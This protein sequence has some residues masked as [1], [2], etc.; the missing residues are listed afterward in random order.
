MLETGPHDSVHHS[1]NGEMA[2]YNAPNDMMLQMHHANAN[3]IWAQWQEAN[4]ARLSDYE[5]FR[6]QSRTQRASVDDELLVYG[7]C[8]RPPPVLRR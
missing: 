4:A 8:D 7:L 1:V 2:A 3:R 6:D 5:G